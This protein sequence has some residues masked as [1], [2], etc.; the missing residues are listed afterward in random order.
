MLH[1][2]INVEELEFDGDTVLCRVCGDRASGFHYGVHACEGCKGFFRR[3][4]QQ[5]IQYRSCLKNQQCNIVRVNRNRCQYCRLKKC[6]AVG[7]SRDAVR[8]GRVPKKEKAKIM[9]QMQKVNS[10]SQISLLS[11]I[12]KNE[13]DMVSQIVMSHMKTTDFTKE[14]IELLTKK[15]WENPEFITVP[16]Y[17]ACPL[18]SPTGDNGVAED[19]S[20]N[21][22]PSIKNVVDFAK[23]IPGFPILCQEDQVTLLKAGTFEVLLFHLTCLFDSKTNTMMFHDGRLFKRIPSQTVT[24]SAG[25]LLDSMFDFSNRINSFNLT[26]EEMALFSAIIIVTADRPGLRNSE[27]IDSIQSKI[28]ECLQKMMAKNHPEDPSLFAKLLMKVPDIRTLNALHSEKLLGMAS[29]SKSQTTAQ[30]KTK[31]AAPSNPLP[32]MTVCNGPM[33]AG[34]SDLDPLYLDLPLYPEYPSATGHKGGPSSDNERIIL[35]TPHR[36]KECPSSSSI[37][38]SNVVNS[39]S[40]SSS[41]PKNHQTISEN[42]NISSSSLGVNTSPGVNSSI[43]C[44]SQLDE[45]PIPLESLIKMTQSGD[46]NT[47]KR[48]H[49]E[50]NIISSKAMRGDDGSPI[51]HNP[52]YPFLDTDGAGLGLSRT[53]PSESSASCSYKPHKK[54]DVCKRSS[55]SMSSN[56]SQLDSYLNS[57]ENSPRENSPDDSMLEILAIPREYPLNSQNSEQNFKQIET[58]NKSEQEV[59]RQNYQCN[60]MLGERLKHINGNAWQYI[61][62]TRSDEM[63]KHFAKL[64]QSGSP[65]N[66]MHESPIVPNSMDMSVQNKMQQYTDSHSSNSAFPQDQRPWLAS[67]TQ[68]NS[69]VACNLSPRGVQMSQH[70]PPGMLYPTSPAKGLH[71]LPDLINM[72]YNRMMVYNKGSI[73]QSQ[74]MM[75]SSFAGYQMAHSLSSNRQNAPYMN[76]QLN[77]HRQHIEWQKQTETLA[78]YKDMGAQRDVN[79]RMTSVTPTHNPHNQP[80]NLT[81]GAQKSDDPRSPVYIKIEPVTVT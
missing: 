40:S 42:S 68:Y 24:N 34:S 61:T 8:F 3:S 37:N 78:P 45:G 74:Q 72:Q 7:M 41:S 71:G 63:R 28:M 30:R 35:H 47:R 75:G 54:F 2:G 13:T 80:L 4:I 17:L 23:Q 15:A 31:A 22:I 69:Q 33:K 44:T 66:K 55:S 27:Q 21:F 39:T 36:I 9:E 26:D 46:N 58:G 60:S 67:G 57:R 81:V 11:S 59:I 19:M 73:H 62:G 10:Q 53:S 79:H 32:N 52:L 5:K 20:S 51:F 50:P 14:K 64:S 29:H 1:Q 38:G 77:R 25:F 65:T 56:N 18:N 43:T 70:F 12:L 49:P 6:I 76:Q 16:Q 48:P